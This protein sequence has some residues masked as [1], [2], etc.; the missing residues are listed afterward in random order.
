MR[1]ATSSSTR[2]LAG[3]VAWPLAARAQQ[4]SDRVLHVGIL[5]PNSE[6]EPEA[7]ARN[8][9]FREALN[10]LGWADGR[11]LRIDYR[12][13]ATGL[14]RARTYASELVNLA[15]NVILGTNSLCAEAL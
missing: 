1:M 3:A 13:G 9:A 5:L 6:G 8:A 11:N 15:P 4:S 10:K 14:E 12:W 7:Q 2:R